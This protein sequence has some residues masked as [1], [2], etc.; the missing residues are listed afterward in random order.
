MKK[1]LLVFLPFLLLTMGVFIS[2]EEVEEASKYDNWQERNEAYIDSL[3]LIVNGRADRIIEGGKYEGDNGDSLKL[4]KIPVGEL[5]AIKDSYT[6]T[7]DN[8]H[9]IY[10][11]KIKADNPKG[12]RPLYTQSF[13]AYYYGTIIIGER[14][15]GN[16]TGYSAIDRGTLDPEGKT[17]TDFDSPS[18][19]SVTGVI[20]GWTTIIQYMYTDERWMVYVPYQSAYG[21]SGR[22]SIPGYTTLIYDME[23]VSVK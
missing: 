22:G 21:T 13:S 6:S 20:T 18:T 23:L 4:S 16:F 8:P 3:S 14:F 1:R 9:Y 17:W 15:D 11:K 2:C 12:Q 19:F 7:T 10:C 5:F